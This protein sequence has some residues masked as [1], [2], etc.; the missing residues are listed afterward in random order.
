[1]STANLGLGYINPDDRLDTGV[2]VINANSDVIDTQVANKS[3]LNHVHEVVGE[4]QNTLVIIIP[5]LEETY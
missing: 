5:R 3:P 2:A 1:M 4:T